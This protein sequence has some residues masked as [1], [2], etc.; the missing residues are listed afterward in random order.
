MQKM[1]LIAL[2]GIVAGLAAGC[3]GSDADHGNAGTV[4]AGTIGAASPTIK[5]A[6]FASAIFGGGGYVPGLIYHP[7]TPD[8]LYARTDV[9]GAYR[10]DPATS[11]WI[12]I[13]DGF[14]ADEGGYHGSETMALGTGA[15]VEPSITRP[16][17]PQVIALRRSSGISIVSLSIDAGTSRVATTRSRS[18]ALT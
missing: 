8:L 10:W 4:L 18:T 12:S 15:R 2:A 16:F 13:T 17:T 3:G 6:R 9:G 11:S 7:T 1:R 14:G 5:T